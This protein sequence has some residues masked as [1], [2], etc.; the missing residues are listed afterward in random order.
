MSTRYIH[1][2]AQVIATLDLPA[3]PSQAAVTGAES[4][5][6]AANAA[7]P[8]ASGGLLQ[9]AA[10]TGPVTRVNFQPATT[11]IPAGYYADT[12]KL[13]GMRTNGLSYG[14]TAA[15]GATRQQVRQYQTL[16]ELATCAR[17]R[18]TA[19]DTA[20]IWELS[21]P[22]GAYTVALICGDPLST[23]QTNNLRIEGMPVTDPDPSATAG[24]TQGDF[25]GYAVQVVVSDGKLTMTV[26]T[27]AVDPKLCC[28][29]VG[30]AWTGTNGTILREWWTGVTGTLVSNLTSQAAYPFA[31]SGSSLPT[32][33][34]APVNWADTYGTRLRGYVTAPTTGSYR[35][36]IASD[37]SSE[38]WVS[39]SDNPTA[40]VKVASVSGYTSSQQ[41]TK[42]PSQQSVAITLTAGVRYYLEALHKEGGGG[43]N[44]AVGWTLPSGA[45][46]RPIPGTRLTPWVIS[47]PATAT[48]V[49]NLVTTAT[50]GTFLAAQ[51]TDTQRQYAPGSYIDEVLAYMQ[52]VGGNT[53]RFYPHA[54]HLYSVA[55]LTDSTGAVVERYS[56]NA[57]GKQTITGPSG[58]V[59]SRSSVGWDRGFTGYVADNETSLLHARARQYSPTLGRFIGRNQFGELNPM[60]YTTVIE[61]HLVNRQFTI[62]WR[63]QRL[64][65]NESVYVYTA[66]TN[67]VQLATMT[68][69]SIERHGSM[70]SVPVPY[71]PKKNYVDGLI[72]YQR[73]S[74]LLDPSGQPTTIDDII[75]GIVEKV[76]DA[77]TDLPEVD[78]DDLDKCKL[79]MSNY[80]KHK[81]VEACQ[82]M[83]EECDFAL[84]S[85]GGAGGQ[86]GTRV[87][88]GKI[89]S[90]K[91]KCI[92]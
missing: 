2:G 5:G 86:M 55:A 87:L 79:A 73:N 66:D 82:L 45:Q 23:L 14:W 32:I 65:S 17:M 72:L 1:S 31:P 80:K 58:G 85:T 52:T 39:T 6:T 42:Y 77:A 81:T 12:G 13:Y 67:V 91:D 25:D 71:F 57:Y 50:N 48:R 34:E 89:E 33:A 7:L 20:G 76:G 47:D 35:F 59:R 22:N 90:C 61:G 92:Q 40:R 15:Q 44:L 37:D 26:G 19:G 68:V 46:E 60:R 64:S 10:G 29:E 28:L 49:T 78:K 62:T 53:Q 8:P 9:P 69:F 3:V 56:Y 36:W 4:D 54:N 18:P 84:G 75:N 74:S 30:P 51:P 83:C 21:V 38:L 63:G 27:G 41:W 24:Y 70:E 16:P 88:C 11:V 43:D